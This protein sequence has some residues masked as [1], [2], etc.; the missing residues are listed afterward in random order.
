M[1][2]QERAAPK[3]RW[4]RGRPRAVPL[5]QPALVPQGL[6][7]LRLGAVRREVL[8]E[9]DALGPG[10]EMSAGGQQWTFAAPALAAVEHVTGGRTASIGELAV[11]SSPSVGQVTTLVTELVTA[12]IAA[13]SRRR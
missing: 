5:L 11:A 8:L 2:A 9:V 3:H 13:I 1:R 4:L 6:H 12:D 7:G 10:D